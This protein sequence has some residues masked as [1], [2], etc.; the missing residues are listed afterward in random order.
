MQQPYQG[1]GRGSGSSGHG[2][3][4]PDC[5]PA[6]PVVH[7][8]ECGRT[9]CG[10]TGCAQRRGEESACPVTLPPLVRTLRDT[11]TDEVILSMGLSP[12]RW[13]GRMLAPAIWPATRRFA[14]LAARFDEDLSAMGIREA[15][16]RFLPHLVAGCLQTGAETIPP[17]GPLLVASNHPGATDGLAILAAMPREDV[18]I[19]GSDVP[20]TR[21]LPHTRDHLI[22]TPDQLTHTSE[23]AAKGVT[24]ARSIIRRLLAGGAVLIFPSGHL[25]PDPIRSPNG[26]VEGLAEWSRSVALVLRHV[27]Q[28]CLLVTMVS[29][30]LVPGFLSH[31]LTRL[32]P[33]GWE[34]Q[35]LAEVLQF[36]QQ[37]LF[38]TRY[39]LVPR[40]SFGEPVSAQELSAGKTRDEL[41]QAIADHAR[42]V[43]M[44]HQASAARA[45]AVAL[46]PIPCR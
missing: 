15:A 5:A 26:A 31:P 24:A 18:W 29:G 28:A 38:R 14:E 32:A 17:T 8:A 43:L 37:L 46:S 42:Q 25:D 27:P 4:Q 35:K 12:T 36:I 7:C 40:V 2:T 45:M 44:Q 33:R 11:I 6:H 16:R 34:R 39:G 20:F 30:V 22:Y 21:A 23:D 41:V 19:V 1:V 13:P 3:V 9:P 10:R